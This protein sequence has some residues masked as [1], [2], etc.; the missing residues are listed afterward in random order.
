[1]ITK[2]GRFK[3]HDGLA[4]FWKAFLPQET[5][6]AVVHVIHGFAEHIDRYKN[7][8]DELV[9]A[10]YAVAG[11]DHRGHGR[12]EGK[13]CHV[14]SFEEYIADEKQFADEIIKTLFP[15]IPVAL[16]GHSMGSQIAMNY[17]ERYPNDIKSLVLS[18]T[19][20]GPGSAI[21]K[22][23]HLI[24][25]IASRLIPGVHIKSPL[26]PEFISHDPEVVKAYVED[27]LVPDVITPRLGEQMWTY[28]AIGYN[29]AG[30]LTMP[31]LIQYGTEDTSFSGQ[32]DFFK[33][34][35]ASDKTIKAYEGFRHEVYNERPKDRARA[36]N[37]LHAWLDKHM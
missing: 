12:S 20:A 22:P 31:T 23:L 9:P 24:T 15:D 37:D 6:E 33:A 21:P 29:N 3:A 1:M 25:R 13:R 16:L 27:P 14:N 28:N 5:P 2:E 10:G 30:K 35:G 32:N 17:A 8:I 36:L 34:V 7:V 4:I 19:G 11:T 26:P 18:G